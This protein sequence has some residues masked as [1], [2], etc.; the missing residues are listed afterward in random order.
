MYD[1]SGIQYFKSWEHN[2]AIVLCIRY[3]HV[4]AFITCWVSVVNPSVLLN[5][6]F[7]L[8]DAPVVSAGS[9]NSCKGCG[10]VT[11][12]PVMETRLTSLVNRMTCE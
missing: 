6:P 5:N 1:S 8:R 3:T 4:S 12:Q 10:Q 9:V 2:R 7:T 11:V